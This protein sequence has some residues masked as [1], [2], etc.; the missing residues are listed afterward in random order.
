MTTTLLSS[1]SMVAGQDGAPARPP[2]GSDAWRRALRALAGRYAG[3]RSGPVLLARATEAGCDLQAAVD[4]ALGRVH[5]LPDDAI[6]PD[7]AGPLLA[8]SAANAQAAV[9]LA[10]LAYEAQP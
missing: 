7:I 3:D 1:L 10:G 6:H 4:L 2:A 5:E 8:L 9:R